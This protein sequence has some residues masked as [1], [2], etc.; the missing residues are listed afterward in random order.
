VNAVVT[1]EEVLHGKILIVDDQEANVLLLERLL[2][3][4]GYDAITT[5]M[6]ATEVCELHRNHAFDLI[7]L[8]LQM[9][10]L[11]GYQVMEGL[12]A[13]EQGG[14]LPVLAITANRDHKLRALQN[15][16]RD[17]V[18]KPFDLAEVLLRVYNML[19]VRLL[20]LASMQ[21][22]QRVLSER[23]LNAELEAMVVVRT[24]DLEQARVEAEQANQAK[25]NFLA[26]MSHEIRTPLNGVIGMIDV[27]N[28]TSLKAYQVEMVELIRESA[29][30][31]LTIIED[32]LDFSKIEAGK[33]DLERTPIQVAEV[34]EKA[35]WMMDGLAEKKGVNLSLFIDPSLPETVLGDA[36]RLRQVL[37]N[38]VSNAIKFSSG[39]GRPGR[40]SLRATLAG[41]GLNQAQVTFQVADNGIGMDPAALQSLFRPFSQADVS[42][43]RRFG[44]TGLGLAITHHLVELIGGFIEVVSEPD[45][46]STF[47]VSLP[48]A[49]LPPGLAAVS[50]PNPIQGL[51]CLVVG[52]SAG[53]AAELAAYLEAAGAQVARAQDLSTASS[54][55]AT[56]SPGLWVWV[57]DDDHPVPAVEVLR[58]TLG[59]RPGVASRFVVVYRGEH[60]RHRR[61][62]LEGPDLV[63]VDGHLLTPRT[64]VQAVAMA[65]GR[66]REGVVEP[67]EGK[68]ARVISPPTHAEALRLGRL[69]L[70]AEDNETNQKVFLQQLALLGFA[71]DVAW[72]G[73]E[74]LALW[75][76]GD[77]ALLLT[78]L[79]MPELDGYELAAA[80]RAEEGGG[81]RLPIIALTA[82]TLPG[83]ARRC[84]EA[85]LD[86]LLNKPTPLVE[87]QAVLEQWLPGA[88]PAPAAAQAPS[89]AAPVEVAV[90]Q[91]LIG[92]D[93]A[94]LQEFLQ[95][96]RTSAAPVAAALQAACAQGQ[97]AQACALAHQLKASA[98]AVGAL[99]LGKLCG[100]LEKAG[101]AGKAAVL[102]ALGRR[103][104][105]A[106]AAVDAYLR[107]V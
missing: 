80:I 67:L 72:N 52:D 103:F 7:L 22:Y 4:A 68:G 2:Q 57:L 35:C 75:R 107:A 5:T 63:A 14:Y 6:D 16:A 15:G 3:G 100:E 98:N 62:R 86:G 36:S 101:K 43:T 99:A 78:D 106:M 77:Y 48:F 89:G 9:P 84:R 19:E 40:V 105:A 37:V 28:Q 49:L 10:G 46:G 41:R 82:T 18:A 33:L 94:T 1:R 96:F 34:L 93:P 24:A 88:A 97:A 104:E 42:T 83:E 32:I 59:Q 81:T 95:H 55:V 87:L 76:S 51:S 53:Q 69:V 31:L 70:I 102:P 39:Q 30:S 74:A 71:A 26:S 60:R 21:L 29:F 91:A 17:F 50:A 73:A 11:D 27:L 64:L 85:G 65:A 47:T 56:L 44:G 25:S 23:T 38:L 54:L 45:H 12:K 92:Q 20:N 90:L 58:A 13:I 8:D 61:P 79:N 66:G